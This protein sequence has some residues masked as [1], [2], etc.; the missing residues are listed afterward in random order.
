[1][2]PTTARLATP[3]T[4][5]VPMLVA[6]LMIIVSAIISHQVLNRLKDTQEQQLRSIVS[7]YIDGLSNALMAP[8]LQ[9]DIWEIYDLLD[10]RP[11]RPATLPP[12]E[13]IVIGRDGKVLASTDPR[14]VPPLSDLPSRYGTPNSLNAGVEVK[15]EERRGFGRLPLIYQDR[16]IGAIHASFDIGHF[17]DER[18]EIFWTLVITNAGLATAFAAFGYLV[19]L[20]M[21]RPMKILTDHMRSGA[22]GT[23]QTIERRDFP[24]PG[25]EFA[26]L[27]EGFNSLVE[28]E[29]ERGSLKTRL[30]D[31]E[32]LASLGL[33]A[34]SMAHEINNPLGGLF[35][36]IDTLK[37]Y[38][39]DGDVRVNA[40]DLLERGLVGIRDVVS[41]A[42]ITY[43][44]ERATRAL[45]VKDLEDVRLLVGPEIARRHQHL[46]WEQCRLAI[47][48]PS[49]TG[50]AIRRALLNLVLNASAAAGDGGKVSVRMLADEGL[51]LTIAVADS[52]S[53]LPSSGLF[54]LTNGQPGSAVRAGNGLGLWMIRQTVDEAGGKILVRSQPES[55]TE[56]T[57]VLPLDKEQPDGSA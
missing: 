49:K 4:V 11:A 13:T 55:G 22:S 26:Q 6:A 10:R 39:A 46:S 35:N 41:A 25:S 33:L 21:V 54:V 27:F 47:R 37:R 7:A 20:Q 31:E 29:R 57:I 56:I 23:P 8:V 2:R 12:I 30:A 45:T 24:K 17:I 51:T 42:L 34:S 16:S 5:K 40:L 52:G 18:G 14:A 36:T 1:M 38:G 32:K 53:G 19:T 43:R 50:H 3:L 15:W 44:P 28:A 48:L 9:N